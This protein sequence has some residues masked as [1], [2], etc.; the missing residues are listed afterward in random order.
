MHSEVSELTEMSTKRRKVALNWQTI[1]SDRS[2]DWRLIHHV[3]VHRKK[4]LAETI[5]FVMIHWLNNYRHVRYDVV[6]VPVVLLHGKFG[7]NLYSVMSRVNRACHV[8]WC[9]ENLSWKTDDWK[10]V[11]FT[12]ENRIV[13]GQ[14]R[15]VEPTFGERHTKSGIS[16]VLRGSNSQNISPCSGAVFARKQWVL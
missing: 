11:E 2:S 9:I 1:K 4:T 8:F 3:E 15:E 7:S 13:I 14:G 16:N 10:S 12:E 6:Y 5:N